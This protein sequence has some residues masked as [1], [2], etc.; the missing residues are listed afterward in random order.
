MQSSSDHPGWAAETVGILGKW[1]D[2]NDASPERTAMLRGALLAF[3]RDDQLQ[4]LVTRALGSPESSVDTQVLLLDVMGRADVPELPAAW[5][6]QLSQHLAASDPRVVRQAVAAIAARRSNRF[7]ERLSAVARDTNQPADVRFAALVLIGRHGGALDTA[8][9]TLL[10]QKL[11]EETDPIDRLAA[12]E[13]L[14]AAA[15]TPRNWNNW[16]LRSP[17]PVRSNCRR[18]CRRSRRIATRRLP[19]N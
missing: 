8:A 5:V 2:Q 3:A 4:K 19:S 13:A 6:E 12:A 16:C 7:D 17:R 1:L 11:G 10:A 9:F 14:G 15:L 18:W